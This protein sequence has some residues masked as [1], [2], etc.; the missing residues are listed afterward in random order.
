MP[1]RDHQLFHL[2][3]FFASAAWNQFIRLMA[4]SQEV[5][6]FDLEGYEKVYASLAPHRRKRLS[7]Q[8]LVIIHIV[9]M[10]HF[11]CTGLLSQIH[12]CLVT[13]SRTLSQHYSWAIV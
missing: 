12:Y 6:T 4:P 13:Q 11:Y 3:F 10:K 9:H 7:Y 8:L 5:N 1:H 2:A